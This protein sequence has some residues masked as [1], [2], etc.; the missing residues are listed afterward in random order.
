[1]A[2]M[3]GLLEPIAQFKNMFKWLTII[4]AAAWLPFIKDIIEALPFANVIFWAVP[5]AAIIYAA[6]ELTN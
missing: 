5:I 6:L 3:K 2:G 4:G 1:M